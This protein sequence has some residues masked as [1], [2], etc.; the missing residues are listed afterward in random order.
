MPLG[1]S[2]IV[3]KLARC[4]NTPDAAPRQSAQDSG[5]RLQPCVDG[6]CAGCMVPV[7][8]IAPVPGIPPPNTAHAP[9]NV[10][11]YAR[12]SMKW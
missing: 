9:R 4:L 11:R 7:A 12:Q 8:V 1:E 10:Y 6:P 5:A 2:A 3:G